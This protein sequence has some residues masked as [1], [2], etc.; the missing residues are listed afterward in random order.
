MRSLSLNLCKKFLDSGVVSRPQK[1]EEMY[2]FTSTSVSSH[3]ILCQY[4]KRYPLRSF[5]KV[6]FVQFRSLLRYIKH[7]KMLPW[8]GKVLKKVE[9]LIKNISKVDERVRVL[10]ER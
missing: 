7:R 1:P 6:S 2:R 8:Q 10:H 4:L 9:N 5:K 3:E